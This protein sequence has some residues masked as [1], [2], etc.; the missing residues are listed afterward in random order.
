MTSEQTLRFDTIIAGGTVIDGTGA[1]GVR[2]DVGLI[3]DRIAAVGTLDG[4]QAGKRIDATGLT[5]APGFIDCHTHD[6][7]YLLTSPDMSAKVSQGVTSVVIGNCGISLAPTFGRP[8]APPM[9]LL[10]ADE[11]FRFRSFKGFL[12]ALDEAPAAVN[13]LPLVG[14]TTLRRSIMEDLEKA[15]TLDDIDAMRQLFEDSLDAGVLGFSTGLFYPNAAASTPK[16]VIGVAEPAKGMDLVYATHLRNEADFIM[17]ALEEAFGIARQLQSRLVLSHHK[18]IGVQNH[19]RATE[20]LGRVHRQRLTQ[21]I[22]LDLYPYT[23][24]SSVLNLKTVEDT[25]RVVISW[26]DP[27]PEMAGRDLEEVCAEWNLPLAE[28]IDR[29]SPAG[30]ILFM[31]AEKD[32]QEI[33]RYEATMI[34]S[35]GLPNDKFPH[36]RLWGTFP[37][38]LGHYSRDLGL[39][40]L[41]EAVH[42]MTGLTAQ[43]FGLTDRGRIAPGCKADLTLFDARTIRDR[44]DWAAPTEPAEGIA[45]VLVNGTTV[46]TDGQSTGARPGQAVRRA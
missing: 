42:R 37:R 9:N 41:P 43:V 36:P 12:D 22:A 28:T 18:L 11:L 4:A 2:A 7:G 1:P 14:L 26:S 17:P 40:D 29:L 45:H 34:G 27:H 35:D 31:M 5:V 46:W 10:G 13:A 20:T 33:L 32:V 39:I 24:G 25:E 19:G 23:A 3:D 8:P 6:D 38:I 15:A 30:G 21:D 16:E 44:A